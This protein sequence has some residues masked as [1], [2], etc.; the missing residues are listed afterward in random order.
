ME[1]FVDTSLSNSGKCKEKTYS[2][3]I[4]LFIP[5]IY[6]KNG[7]FIDFFRNRSGKKPLLIAYLRQSTQERGLS[8]FC[9]RQPLKNLKGY[10]PLKQTISLQI[11]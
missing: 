1:L 7:F 9:G 2:S 5:R 4:S 11:F 10:A 8:K 3:I 6:F